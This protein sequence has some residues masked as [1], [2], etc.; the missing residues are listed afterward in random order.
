MASR[1]FAERMSVIAAS[2]VLV[3]KALVSRWRTDRCKHTA[4]DATD[5][6]HSSDTLARI[7]L[8]ELFRELRRIMVGTTDFDRL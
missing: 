4:S 2:D 5:K 7:G 8:F 1:P 3:A 6:K